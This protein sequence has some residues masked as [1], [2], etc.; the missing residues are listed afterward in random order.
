ML[1]TPQR[2]PRAGSQSYPTPAA[3]ANADGSTTVY[4]GP[5]KPGRGQA[6]QLG[7]NRSE[8]RA[9]SRSCVS[10]ARSNRSSPR[11]GVRA[12]SN[13]SAER[14]RAACAHPNVMGTHERQRPTAITRRQALATAAAVGAFPDPDCQCLKRRMRSQRVKRSETG[15]VRSRY[16]RPRPRFPVPFPA[17]R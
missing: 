9:G 14:A 17:T 2:Y 10:T 13:W 16:P 1:D 8:E 6:R 5:S 15:G 3:E 4:F 11:R 12:R 7:S